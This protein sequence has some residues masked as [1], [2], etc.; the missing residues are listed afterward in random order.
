MKP[1]KPIRR[2][3]PKRAKELAK[4]RRLKAKFLMEHSVCVRC[5]RK[6]PLEGRTLHHWAGRRNDLLCWVP[7]FRM[8]CF[9]CHQ[10]IERYRN[11]AVKEGFRAPDNLFGRASLVI[12]K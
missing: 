7:G 2:A 3:T 8:A 4:Y 6:I 11:D 1:R 10:Q 5:S 12:P 9:D